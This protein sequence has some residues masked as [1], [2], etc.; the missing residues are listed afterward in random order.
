MRDT[1]RLKRGFHFVKSLYLC[2]Y[3]S[4][5]PSYG[6][7]YIPLSQY[8]NLE[9]VVLVFNG[10][11]GLRVYS[12]GVEVI[13]STI[14]WSSSWLGFRYGIHVLQKTTDMFRSSG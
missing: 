5:P 9:P 11:T 14:L 6:L 2:S 10:A 3:I 4:A 8:D 12:G 13:S 7:E 1:L